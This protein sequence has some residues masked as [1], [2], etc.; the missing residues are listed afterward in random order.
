MN[1]N[2]LVIALAL[3]VAAGGASAQRIYKWTD[4]QGRPQFSDRPPPPGVQAEE[5][6]VFSGRAE[7]VPSFSIR[8]VAANFPVALYTA[9]GCGA[10]CDNARQLLA[11]RG[12]PFTEH[13][14]EGTEEG[15]ET[16]R[17]IFGSPETVPAATVGRQILKGFSEESWHTLLDQAGYPRTA[18]PPL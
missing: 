18:P 6:R 17:Q 3:L 15:L 2:T 4:E 16:Y 8:A 11:T 14:V 1:R 9:E 12:I 7:Q 13:S 5:Q 10:P